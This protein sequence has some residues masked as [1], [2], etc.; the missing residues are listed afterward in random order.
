MAIIA[1]ITVEWTHV[2]GSHVDDKGYHTEFLGILDVFFSIHQC[3]SE[4]TIETKPEESHEERGWRDYYRGCFLSVISID[5]LLP[6][7]FF[8]LLHVSQWESHVGKMLMP[9]GWLDF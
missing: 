9:H 6:S 8:P 7:F 1:I 3:G 5:W 2:G 4:E